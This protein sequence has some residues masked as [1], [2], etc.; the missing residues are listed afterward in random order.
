MTPRQEPHPVEGK[1]HCPRCNWYVDMATH[2]VADCEQH[3]K[4][5]DVLDAHPEK[6][7]IPQVFQQAFK[8][9]EL[10]L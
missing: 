10:E 1:E 3:R 7:L 6:T 4:Y 8:E 9:G 2:T 5:S